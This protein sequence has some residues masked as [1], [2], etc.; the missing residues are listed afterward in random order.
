MEK[1]Q[2]IQSSALTKKDK[3][4]LAEVV[5]AAMAAKWSDCEQLKHFKLNG[6]VTT[7]KTFGKKC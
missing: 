5:V 7:K 1:I 2:I 3:Q 4:S 6:K